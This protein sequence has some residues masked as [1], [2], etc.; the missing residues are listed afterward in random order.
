M[1]MDVRFVAATNDDLQDR[2][3]RGLFR[4]DLYFRLAQY[5]VV[6]PPRRERT[7]DIAYLTQRFL[8]EASIEL[9]RPIQSIVPDALELLARYSWPGNV[10]ELRNAVRRAVLQTTG[11]AIH[12]ET[13][14]GVLGSA[15]AGA[16]ADAPRRE[17]LSLREIAT[18]AA[19][20]AE[21]Q[22]IAETLKEANGTRARRRK[23]CGPITRRFT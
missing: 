3:S 1:P 4:A 8:E 11:L 2:V 12:A 14:Q 22:A 16:A 10:R 17:A 13:I 15:E 6:L 5:T 21:R 19:A 7:A 18:S 9:R 20:S 23:R